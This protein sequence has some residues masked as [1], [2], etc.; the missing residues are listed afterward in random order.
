MPLFCDQHDNAQRIAE[1]GLG[2]R[3]NPFTCTEKQL[4]TTID[5]LLADD[6]L[7]QRMAK[8]GER[9][10]GSMKEQRKAVADSIEQICSEHKLRDRGHDIIFVIDKSFQGR[11]ERY[12]FKEHI[13]DPPP[14]KEKSEKD[15]EY[16]DDKDFWPQF[17]EK[18]AARYEKSP[19]DQLGDVILEAFTIMADYQNLFI[20]QYANL[21]E[22]IQ[23]DLIIHDGY[24][25]FPTIVNQSIPWVWLFSASPHAMLLD[26]RVPPFYSGLPAN[27]DQ[28]EWRAYTEK[29]LEHLAP[30]QKRAN[31]ENLASGGQD[32]KGRLHPFS[33]FLNIFMW[34]KELMYPELADDLPEN[35]VGVDCFVRTVPE[36]KFTLP[37]QLANR[38][39]KLVL[40]SMG[41]FGC[42]NL[43]LMTR[44][45]GMLAKS[46][47]R[48]IV[49]KAR[50]STIYPGTTSGVSPF[51]RRLPF[52]SRW[53]CNTVTECFFYGVRLLVLPLFG[54]QFDNAQ[55]IDET[56]LGKRL[57]P[58]TCTEEELLGAIDSLLKNDQLANRMK[59]IGE[60]IRSSQDK[61]KVADLIE[62]KLSV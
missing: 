47:H 6:E 45:V 27:G 58:V 43:K 30:L 32:L 44:L 54:D 3:L 48:F 8:I 16:D 50:S 5:D 7:T 55:R 12:G 1:T 41:S 60:R 9:I 11:L 18:N 62:T 17:M 49:S 14:P 57:N 35:V 53:I 28:A 15:S 20:D 46:K 51:S 33:S 19:I 2:K 34:P 25:C 61:K 59:K 26:P 40:F 42:A 23:P 52:F 22:K 29:A 31:E 39:G 24:I 38:P 10:R 37:A 21:V 56:G 13:L 36:Q 4:L